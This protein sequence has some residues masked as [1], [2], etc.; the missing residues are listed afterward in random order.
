M[1]L[2]DALICRISTDQTLALAVRD[3]PVP[4]GLA[5]ARA[6]PRGVAWRF[7]EDELSPNRGPDLRSIEI[8]TPAVARREDEMNFLVA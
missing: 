3:G 5:Q 8:R 1:A 7:A 2:S 6:Q 4:R